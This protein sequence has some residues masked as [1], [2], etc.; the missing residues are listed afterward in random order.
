MFTNV[1][2]F[3]RTKLHSNESKQFFRQYSKINLAVRQTNENENKKIN[4]TEPS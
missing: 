4:E 3:W 2:L 1:Y